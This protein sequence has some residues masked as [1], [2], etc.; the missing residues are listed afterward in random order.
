MKAREATRAVVAS[1]GRARE[2]FMR[3]LGKWRGSIRRGANIGVNWL[4]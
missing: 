4:E 2:K 1:R 3:P